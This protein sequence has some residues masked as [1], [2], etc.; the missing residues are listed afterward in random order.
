MAS[1]NAHFYFSFGA[2]STTVHKV[3]EIL[4]TEEPVSSFTSAYLQ[5]ISTA[6]HDPWTPKIPFENKLWK[7]LATRFILCDHHRLRLVNL[8][9]ATGFIPLFLK[10]FTGFDF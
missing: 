9:E 3:F 5:S 2:T 6:A 10:T 7:T 8:I 4:V 1:L